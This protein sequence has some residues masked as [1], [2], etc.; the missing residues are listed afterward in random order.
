MLKNKWGDTTW[1][2][3]IFH[4]GGATCADVELTTVQFYQAGFPTMYTA[5][6]TRSLFSNHGNLPT[7]LEQGDYNCWYRHIKDKYTFIYPAH[8]RLTFYSQLS[9][10]HL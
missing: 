9:I 2:Q 6:V 1:K 4:H 3:A 10:Q 8:A 5:C 7:L